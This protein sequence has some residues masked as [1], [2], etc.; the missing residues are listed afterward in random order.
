MKVTTIT[1]AFAKTGIWPLNRRAIPPIMFKPSLN[2]TSQPIDTVPLDFPTLLQPVHDEAIPVAQ[3]FVPSHP[4]SVISSVQNISTVTSTSNSS[5]STATT[6]TT[7]TTSTATTAVSHS[8]SPPRFTI[9][10]LPPPPPFHAS[11]SDLR[12]QITTLRSLL[13]FA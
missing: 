2:T 7:T 8:P 11:R 12:N 9:A 1:A 4:L 5:T 10:G 3:D 6:T 13:D